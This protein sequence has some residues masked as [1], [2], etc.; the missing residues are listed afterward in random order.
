MAGHK[1]QNKKVIRGFIEVRRAYNGLSESQWILLEQKLRLK[2]LPSSD[3]L[4]IE[5]LNTIFVGI[6]LRQQ[7]SPVGQV[8]NKILNLRRHIR[9][10]RNQIGFRAKA[11]QTE[12][13][14]AP[15]RDW[16]CKAYFNTRV[17]RKIPPLREL[18]L[19][20]H[21]LDAAIATID[22][23]VEEQSAADFPGIR[24]EYMWLVW[25]SAIESVLRK[26]GI[27]TTASS[28]TGKQLRESP[29]VA[30][31]AAMQA[32]LPEQ[33]QRFGKNSSIAKAIQRARREVGRRDPKALLLFMVEHWAYGG[34]VFTNNRKDTL[35]RSLLDQAEGYMWQERQR[36]R[37]LIDKT[38]I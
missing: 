10:L 21:A 18:Q 1:G 25:A 2:Q 3:R 14:F 29:F 28:D 15:D 26:S 9:V 31:I 38:G 34:V 4:L 32:Y 17:I 12:K 5:E 27:R 24:V 13:R 35:L 37:K 22:L 33:C 7:T 30:F 6:S 8:T 19:L 11:R 36:R 23:V 16:L 20:A